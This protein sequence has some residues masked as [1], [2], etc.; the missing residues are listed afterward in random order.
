VNKCEEDISSTLLKQQIASEIS[1]LSS[2]NGKLNRYL[3]EVVRLFDDY[4]LVPI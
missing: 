4:Q 1:L 2:Q 3:R